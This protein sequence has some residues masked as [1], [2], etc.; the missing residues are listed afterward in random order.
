MSNVREFPGTSGYDE[1]LFR[2][3][4]YKKIKQ[5]GGVLTEDIVGDTFLE[6]L[7]DADLIKEQDPGAFTDYVQLML[8]I[9]ERE[10]ALEGL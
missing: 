10:L 3:E 2:Q 9:L 6:T 1:A 5:N 8:A 7:P 4:V